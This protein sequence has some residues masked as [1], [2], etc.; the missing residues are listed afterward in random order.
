MKTK[1][2]DGLEREKRQKKY[3]GFKIQLG[4]KAKGNFSQFSFLHFQQKR[5]LL[6]RAR[7][8]HTHVI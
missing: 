2:V 6:L 5:Y 4:F 1:V 8:K 3:L 7:S